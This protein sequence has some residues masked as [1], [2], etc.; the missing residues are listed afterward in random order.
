[1]SDEQNQIQN[2][3][4]NQPDDFS[5]NATP[6]ANQNSNEPTS[7]GTTVTTTP[8]KKDDT[9]SQH[10]SNYR[11]SA[12][13]F[14]CM[15]LCGLNTVAQLPMNITGPFALCCITCVCSQ[16][17]YYVGVPHDDADFCLPLERAAWND[18]HGKKA[19][20][21]NCCG[22]FFIPVAMTKHYANELAKGC[23]GESQQSVY[24]SP[25]QMK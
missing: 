17:K 7:E 25:E 20:E 4:K 1:M 19:R 18:P 16:H 22:G 3:E 9:T 23:R 2:S 6:T 14:F 21:V 24:P 8:P 11:E 12:G 10:T 15:V 5:T 13:N